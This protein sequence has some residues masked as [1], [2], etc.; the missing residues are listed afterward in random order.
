LDGNGLFDFPDV[1]NLEAAASVS[2]LGAVTLGWRKAGRQ[3]TGPQGG[4]GGVPGV[5]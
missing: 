5:P 4:A 1:R 2:I 3:E